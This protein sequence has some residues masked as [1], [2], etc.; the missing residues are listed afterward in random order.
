MPVRPHP[1]RI[2]VL[3]VHQVEP[4]WRGRLPGSK[5]ANAKL[6]HAAALW[7]LALLR[8]RVRVLPEAL[9]SSDE[10]EKDRPSG[11]ATGN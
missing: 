9:Q 5:H 2:P 7:N 6:R 4:D 10:S 11:A 3:A 1:Q 8:R